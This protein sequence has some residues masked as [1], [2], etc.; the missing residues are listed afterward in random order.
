MLKLK[1][2]I[3]GDKF[4]NQNRRAFIIIESFV[5]IAVLGILVITKTSTYSSKAKDSNRGSKAR[6]MFSMVLTNVDVT[7]ENDIYKPTKLNFGTTSGSNDMTNLYEKTFNQKVSNNDF[8]NYY[9]IFNSVE[10]TTSEDDWFCVITWSKVHEKGLCICNE[11]SI[12]K[13]CE[14]KGAIIEDEAGTGK[15]QLGNAGA[16]F[17]GNTSTGSSVLFP[18]W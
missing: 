4:F 10:T 17:P 8:F 7:L 14:T 12:K 18:T 1:Q 15:L 5:V 6:Q 11:R 9:Y 3:F 2:R 13:E 16:N